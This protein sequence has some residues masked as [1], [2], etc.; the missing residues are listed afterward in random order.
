MGGGR[1]AEHPAHVRI[2][3]SV[4][5]LLGISRRDIVRLT[6]LTDGQ[7]AMFIRTGNY[8]SRK[9]MTVNER[10]AEIDGLMQIWR[11]GMA[12]GPYDT[13][14]ENICTEARPLRR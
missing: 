9:D 5:W 3:V 11:A 4:M 14:L 13:I 7:V 2:A 10:Q 12:P 8:N 6:G 1:P